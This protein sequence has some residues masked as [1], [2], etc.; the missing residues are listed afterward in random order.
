MLHPRRSEDSLLA[1]KE[2]STSQY[3]DRRPAGHLSPSPS[4]FVRDVL[5]SNEK[6]PANGTF[7]R[8]TAGRTK[9]LGILYLTANG[10]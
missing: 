2:G 4:C 8:V 5:K 6:V 7:I 9:V 3:S 1:L 10:L